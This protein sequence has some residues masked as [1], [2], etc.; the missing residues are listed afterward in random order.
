MVDTQHGHGDFLTQCRRLRPEILVWESLRCTPEDFWGE[1]ELSLVVA[2][3]VEAR[4]DVGEVVE[5]LTIVAAAAAVGGVADSAEN[6]KDQVLSL[7]VC[8]R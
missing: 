4:W 3:R 7:C 5:A 2:K 1:V 6:E 8:E